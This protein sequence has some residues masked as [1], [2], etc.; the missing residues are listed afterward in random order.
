MHKNIKKNNEVDGYLYVPVTYCILSEYPYFY[1]FN[2]ICKNVFLQM[3]KKIMI[4][5]L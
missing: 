3:K 2:E 4:K 1:H 5:F